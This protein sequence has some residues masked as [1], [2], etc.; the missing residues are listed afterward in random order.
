MDD[1]DRNEFPLPVCLLS[2]LLCFTFTLN[3][4]WQDKKSTIFFTPSYRD[5]ITAGLTLHEASLL[6]SSLS[7]SFPFLFFFVLLFTSTDVQK[8]PPSSPF[9]P[10]CLQHTRLGFRIPLGDF[11]CFLFVVVMVGLV[12]WLVGWVFIRSC[13]LGLRAG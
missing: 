10:L 11:P 13:G 12:G 4:L 3:T 1:S 8:F 6:F 2:F 7:L 9:L 5:K